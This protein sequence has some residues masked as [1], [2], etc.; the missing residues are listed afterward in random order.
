MFVEPA[1][2]MYKSSFTT[3]DEANNRIIK[4]MNTRRVQYK[5]L[6]Y[7]NNALPIDIL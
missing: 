4:A 3:R 2:T 5:N 1:N 7:E 6:L